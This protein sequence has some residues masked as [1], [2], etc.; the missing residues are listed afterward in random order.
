MVGDAWERR[1]G[2][3]FQRPSR[4]ADRR[5][6]PGHPHP[7]DPAARFLGG[8]AIGAALLVRSFANMSALERGFDPSGLTTITLSFDGTDAASREGREAATAVIREAVLGLPGVRESAWS[9][10]M[11]IV[12]GEVT[13]DLP[14]ATTIAPPVQVTGVGP[15]YFDVYQLRSCVGALFVRGTDL[16]SV[17]VGQN[18]A[19]ALWPDAEA[20]G[21][22]FTWSKTTMQVVGVVAEP[23]QSLLDADREWLD[24]LQHASR[25]AGSL[26]CPDRALRRPLP[27][28]RLIPAGAPARGSGPGSRRDVPR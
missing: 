22:T 6:A 28:R 25:R 8:P 16:D 15:A 13:S 20:V 17:V 14:G 4:H 19:A 9:R 7:A 1:D 11:G 10:G 27:I 24:F 12:F 3:A 5:G 26:P 23:R 21:R 18:L 2:P